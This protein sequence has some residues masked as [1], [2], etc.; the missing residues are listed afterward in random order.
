MRADLSLL[1]IVLILAGFVCGAFSMWQ[2]DMQFSSRMWGDTQT[3]IRFYT[4][5]AG[6][7]F[8]S[9]S[10]MPWTINFELFPNMTAGVAYDVLMI[11]NLSGF[12]LVAAGGYFINRQIRS[13]RAIGDK[14]DA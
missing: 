13:K 3:N 4:D 10:Q 5:L 1:G 11:M 7:G 2:L 6:N 14:T 9:Y 8:K 12:F